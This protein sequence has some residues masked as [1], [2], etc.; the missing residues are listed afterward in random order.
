MSTASTVVKFPL[1]HNCSSRESAKGPLRVRKATREHQLEHPVMVQAFLTPTRRAF[2][3]FRRLTRFY[4][5]TTQYC[6]D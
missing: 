5:S 2:H 4:A 3:M 6:V 1:R